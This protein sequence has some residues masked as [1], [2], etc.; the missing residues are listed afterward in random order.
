MK[1][2]IRGNTSL[3]DAT[4]LVADPDCQ[5]LGWP[6]ALRINWGNGE[7]VFASSKVALKRCRMVWAT[8]DEWRSLAEHGFLAAQ[9][10]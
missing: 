6:A 5:E 2:R 9:G 4:L 1:L 8:P 10:P 3:Y 7:P